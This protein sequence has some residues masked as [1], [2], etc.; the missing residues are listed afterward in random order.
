MTLSLTLAV[1]GIE[2]YPGKLAQLNGIPN[3]SW[4][5]LCRTHCMESFPFNFVSNAILSTG[6]NCKEGGHFEERK[7]EKRTANERI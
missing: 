5:E 4:A 2:L 3:H 6:T 1:N 7:T